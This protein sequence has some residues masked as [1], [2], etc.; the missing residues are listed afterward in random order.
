MRYVFLLIPLIAL[1]TLACEDGEKA[2]PS[3]TGAATRLPSPAAGEVDIRD[4]LLRAGDVPPGL[5]EPGQ[6]PE[7]LV[8]TA[9]EFTEG[10]L[11]GEDRLEAQPTVTEEQVAAWGVVASATQAYSGPEPY[12]ARGARLMVTTVV[13]HDRVNGAAAF[14]PLAQTALDREVIEEYLAQPGFDI[15]EYRELAEPML[16][17]G[18]KMV[19]YVSVSPDDQVRLE[20]YDL[21]FRRDRVVAHVQVSA[22][23][24]NVTLEQVIALASALDGRIEDG[25]Q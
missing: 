17:E 10:V 15:L 6:L 24:G 25:L 8:Q 1:L 16:G 18:S 4:L 20:Y 11:T 23:E 19:Y 22:P 3:P 9:Q 14:L 12:P 13:L 21:V 7:P 5:A 2:G